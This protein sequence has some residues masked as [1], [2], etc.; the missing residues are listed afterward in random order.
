MLAISCNKCTTLMGTVVDGGGCAYMG[1]RSIWEFSVLCTPFYYKP[2]TALKKVYYFF[3]SLL[4]FTCPPEKHK[5][6]FYSN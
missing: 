6:G 3:K 1:A 4:K 2:K 5:N